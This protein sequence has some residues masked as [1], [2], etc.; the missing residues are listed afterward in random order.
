MRD[1]V[2][3]L[4][5]SIGLQRKEIILSFNEKITEN[6]LIIFGYGDRVLKDH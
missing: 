3:T 5:Q 1:N 6:D 4:S 2:L